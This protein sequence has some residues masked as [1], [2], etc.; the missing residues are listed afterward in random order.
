[1]AHTHRDKKKLLTRVRRI[2]GQVAA[3]ERA[4]ESDEGDCAQ[5]LVQIAAAKG[6]MHALMMEVLAGHL[7]EHVV[8]AETEA[9]RAREA[10]TI[11]ELLARYAR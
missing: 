6:A 11:M 9:E 8:A 5:V 10:G 7:S 4:L 2:G 3:L 1:M